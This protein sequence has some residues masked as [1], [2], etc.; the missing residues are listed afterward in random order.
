MSFA[1]GVKIEN[2]IAHSKLGLK[3]DINE[4]ATALHGRVDKEVFPATVGRCRETGTTQSIF[5][6]GKLVVVGANTEDR[7]LLG[8]YIFADTLRREMKLK[9]SI[10]N[11]HLNNVVGCFCV[12]EPLNLDL[13][14]EDHGLTAQWD[15]DNFR[16]LCYKP[17]G[18]VSLVLFESGKVIVTGGKATKDLYDSYTDHI[19]DIRKYIKG[20]EYRKPVASVSRTRPW[21]QQQVT[22]KNKYKRKRKN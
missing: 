18:R 7:A 1:H 14:M 10:Y 20:K 16:G 12:G 9:V 22:T 13:F 2:I 4:V 15:P 11:F 17:D 6:S 21:L 3:M 8:S 5:E 19:H